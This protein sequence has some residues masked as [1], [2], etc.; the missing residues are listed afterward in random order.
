MASA[1]G[2]SS[3]AIALVVSD[4]RALGLRH[5]H[6]RRRTTRG[7]NLGRDAILATLCGGG[8][9][10][11]ER[12][13]FLLPGGVESSEV[14]GVLVRFAHQRF[15]DIGMRLRVRQSLGAR[16]YRRI[17]RLALLEAQPDGLEDMGRLFNQFPR[18]GFGDLGQELEE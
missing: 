1:T 10:W 16:E 15:E 6:P 17:G 14:I 18:L 5:R 11:A 8:C 3:G 13:L 7:A 4:D 2:A 12:D 9:A